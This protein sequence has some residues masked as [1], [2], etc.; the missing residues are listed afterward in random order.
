MLFGVV[1]GVIFTR[2]TLRH[3]ATYIKKLSFQ[4]ISSKL[5]L[6]AIQRTPAG[7]TILPRKNLFKSFSTVVCVNPFSKEFLPVAG[8]WPRVSSHVPDVGR[9]HLS[10]VK[11]FSLEPSI[12]LRLCKPY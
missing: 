7:F 8:L 3:Q 2:E 5:S 11:R 9:P 10:S 1:A 12:F 6:P 4:A